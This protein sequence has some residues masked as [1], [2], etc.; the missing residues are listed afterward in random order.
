MSN[1]WTPGPW[2]NHVGRNSVL[3][4][5]EITTTGE[6]K[7]I[8]YISGC[9]D[10]VGTAYETWDSKRTLGEREAYANAE[11]IAL[12][13]EM[14][15]ALLLF[16]ESGPCVGVGKELQPG[17]EDCCVCMVPAYS[18]LEAVTNKIRQINASSEGEAT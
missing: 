1:A 14:A 17:C 4:E 2:E 16:D 3:C 11:V 12:A 13:D 8:A 18:A 5:G 7:V 10:T 9:G 6:A 15:K